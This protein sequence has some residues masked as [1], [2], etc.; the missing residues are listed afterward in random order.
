MAAVQLVAPSATSLTRV[1]LI[2]GTCLKRNGILNTRNQHT[3]TDKN[4]QYFQEKRFHQQ[5]G[6]NVRAGKHDDFH[7]GPYQLLPR[8]S[9][10]SYLRIL[11]EKLPYFLDDVPSPSRQTT[12]ALH[13]EASAHSSCDVM[14]YL[15]SHYTRR[16]I[17][18]NG[19]VV[20]PL[21]ITQ[22][23]SC[24]LPLVGPFEQLIL[25]PTF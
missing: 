4:P 22:S 21:R 20:W 16:W 5:F 11:T 24:G 2:D 17:A 12:W 13:D 14:Q 25:R 10:V 23:H 18:P 3:Y 9:G 8:L 1:L 7:L 6:I 15:E 19:P